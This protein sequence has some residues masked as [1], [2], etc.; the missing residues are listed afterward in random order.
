[1]D[2]K[3]ILILG[4]TSFVGRHLFKYL[5]KEHAVATFYSKKLE[6]GIFFDSLSS[7]LSQILEDF[8]PFSHA[9]ILLGDTNPDSCAEDITKSNALNVTSIKS[10]IKCLNNYGVKPVFTS[11]EVVFDGTKGNYVEENATNPPLIYGKQKMEIENYIQNTCDQYV[12]VRLTKVFGSEKGD[13]TIVTNWLAAIDKN[14]K[15]LCANDQIFSPVYIKDVIRSIVR[16]IHYDCNGVYHVAGNKSFNRL[17]LFKMVI[18]YV[19]D[20][21]DIKIDMAECSIHD[22]P[23]KEK[24]PLNI[25]MKPDKLIKTIGIKLHDTDSVCKD[26]VRN[27]FKT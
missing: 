17:D 22:F 10:V 24:R 5:G 4:G 27:H 23:V 12:I 15:I 25:S 14:Q 8:G 16:L 18:S 1:M 19:R 21:S 11:T 20:Y 13:G 3:K 2:K 7:D 26:I 6:D 9:V